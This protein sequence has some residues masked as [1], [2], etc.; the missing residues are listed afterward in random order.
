MHLSYAAIS[1]DQIT[2]IYQ[3]LITQIYQFRKNTN[4]LT[5]FCRQKTPKENPCAK[6]QRKTIDSTEL[7][8]VSNKSFSKLNTQFFI[9]D[10]KKQNKNQLMK[11]SKK[12]LNL[13]QKKYFKVFKML[14]VE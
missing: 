4:F 14:E 7:F 13:N 6:F 1:G 11:I 2:Q 3:R 9:T 8:L 10:T 12:Y 5:L